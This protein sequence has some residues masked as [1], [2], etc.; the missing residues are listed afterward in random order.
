MRHLTEM[1]RALALSMQYRNLKIKKT[2][3]NEQIICCKVQKVYLSSK[4]HP[5]S[6]VDRRLESWVLSFE[7]LIIWF[8]ILHI[9]SFQVHIIIVSIIVIG[10]RCRQT[11]SYY[12]V[13]DMTSTYIDC[14]LY[15]YF[16]PG[17]NEEEI[18]LTHVYIW[19]IHVYIFFKWCAFSCQSTVYSPVYGIYYMFNVSVLCS[20]FF[21]VLFWF[22]S[23]IFSVG[24]ENTHLQTHRHMNR[25]RQTDRETETGGQTRKRRKA[26]S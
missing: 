21:P 25:N 4:K 15:I 6:V 24:I 26:L 13:H 20:L 18:T 12:Y 16:C 11:A 14:R 8:E 3:R 1:N 23:F 2:K 10:E 5:S 17:Q 9:Q 22:L 7:L 19:I